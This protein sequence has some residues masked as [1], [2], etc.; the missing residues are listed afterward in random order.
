MPYTQ[1]NLNLSDFSC[2]ASMVTPMEYGSCHTKLDQWDGWC[3]LLPPKEHYTTQRD[4]KDLVK[5]ERGSENLENLIWDE[6]F[7]D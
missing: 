7:W 6:N 2:S 5:S 4:Q 1:T 3:A